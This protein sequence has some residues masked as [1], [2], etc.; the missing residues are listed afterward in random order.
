MADEGRPTRDDLTQGMTVAV[1]Q[2]Q[3]NNDSEPIIGDIRQII[4][5]ERTH[6]GG[7]EVKLESGVTGRVVEVRPDE[8]ERDVPQ[9]GG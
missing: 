4:T 7:I 8:H 3:E 6:P 1:E 9:G 5:D 2:D